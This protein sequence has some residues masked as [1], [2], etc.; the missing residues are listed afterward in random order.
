L[1]DDQEKEIKL[2]EILEQDNSDSQEDMKLEQFEGFSYRHVSRRESNTFMMHRD[3]L[4][5]D[6]TR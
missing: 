5:S 4:C 3:S 1:I 6:V 2:Q